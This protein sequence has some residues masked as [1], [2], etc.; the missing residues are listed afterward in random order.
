[1]MMNKIGLKKVLPWLIM[2]VAAIIVFGFGKKIMQVLGVSKS[3]EQIKLESA[4]KAAAEAVLNTPVNETELTQ[5]LGYY[6]VFAQ[7]C[8]SLSHDYFHMPSFFDGIISRLHSANGE[9]IRQLAK[10]YAALDNTKTLYQAVKDKFTSGLFGSD[11]NR[12]FVAFKEAFT[13]ANMT[14]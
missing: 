6:T 12:V 3:D 4:A 11:T 7:D 9:D 5:P 10:T 1:M 8:Y 14:V 2:A 13:R